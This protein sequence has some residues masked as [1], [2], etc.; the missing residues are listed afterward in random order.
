MATATKCLTVL[1]EVGLHAR[2][3]SLIVQTALKFDADIYIEKDDERIPAKSI[4]GVLVL[5]AGKGT[6]LFFIAEG[7]DAEEAIEA[8]TALFEDKFGEE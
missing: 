4:M 7:P 2:P 5:A 1:N 8:I 3:A 6:E